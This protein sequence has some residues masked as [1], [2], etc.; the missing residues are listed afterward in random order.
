MENMDVEK[1]GVFLSVL[2]AAVGIVGAYYNNLKLHKRKERL[3]LVTQQINCFYG[4]LYISSESGKIALD[5]FHEKTGRQLFGTDIPPNDTE[6]EEW[7]VWIE[8]VFIPLNDF[9]EKLILNNAHLLREEIMPEVLLKFVAHSSAHK[10][11]FKK[12]QNGDLTEHEP[13]I[14][15]PYD[16]R[17]YAKSAYLELK[18]EQ[19]KLIGKV[20]AKY[21]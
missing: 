11:M 20:A 19:L 5:A 9:R 15:F 4:P 13:L 10:A 12:W 8:S 16:I 14:E 21:T 1:V 7:R 18:K 17:E 3:D 6:L 2:V